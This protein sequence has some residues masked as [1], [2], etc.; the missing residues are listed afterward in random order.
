MCK[1]PKENI[2]IIKINKSP[3]YGSFS[4]AFACRTAERR[5]VLMDQNP[6]L[7][8]IAL[9]EKTGCPFENEP[10][11]AVFQRE[12]LNLFQ[13][14]IPLTDIELYYRDCYEAAKQGDEA[15]HSFLKFAATNSY[16]FKSAAVPLE[17]DITC[18]TEEYYFENNDNVS[19][20]PH[21]RYD[22]PYYHEHEF[23]EFTYVLA[24]AC[25]IENNE[26]AY[27]LHEG[28]MSITP[29]Y[30]KHM[31]CVLDDNTVI[32]NILVKA[33]TFSQVFPFVLSRE[34]ILS[35]FF[36]NAQNLKNNYVFIYFSLNRDE[37]L[38]KLFTLF[39]Y[40]H[41]TAVPR[42]GILKEY[43]LQVFLGYLI[44]MDSS[45]FV[46]SKQFT[47]RESNPIVPIMR[48]ISDNFKTVSLKSVADAFNYSPQHLSRLIKKETN[49]TFTDIV[50][51]HKLTTACNLLRSTN[52]KI[53]EI[54]E[55]CGFQNREHFTRIFSKIYHMSPSSYRKNH[56]SEIHPAGCVK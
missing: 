22:V 36:T 41:N 6:Y 1:I 33:S 55:I 37:R 11:P 50:Q 18:L 19:L 24:G 51:K 40:E 53:N 26:E 15:L 45:Q 5:F 56:G 48:Y 42:P 25:C 31:V 14:M 39:L 23:F 10:L 13:N 21:L 2:I 30:E 54:S 46:T 52:I 32:M 47:I 9:Y 35:S 7:K 12:A 34:G 27:C 16:P 44:Y 43:L 3:R 38:K 29:P 28:E 49:S 20:C 8:G 17:K 4:A